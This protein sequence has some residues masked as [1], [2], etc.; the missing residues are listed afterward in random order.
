M[1]KTSQIQRLYRQR[2]SDQ[3]RQ[4]K[5]RLWKVLVESFFQKWIAPNDAVLDLGCGFGEFLNHV[6]AGRRIGVD[7][8]PDAPGFLQAGIEFH[9]GPVTD[10]A[11]LPDRSVQVVFTS[12]V[13]EHLASKAEVDRVLAES[14][15]VLAP[16][17]AIIAMGPNLRVLPGKYWD[18]W[19]HVVPITDWS[20]AEALENAGFEIVSRRAR[21][22]PYSTVRSALPAH[23]ALVALYLKMPFVWPIMGGQ[24]L[25]RA[26][27]PI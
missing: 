23:P 3:Q 20:L 24:F 21:F 25:I 6:R 2:F 22:L 15:R 9:H 7:M 19:D 11:F 27:K 26:R 5:A 16:G 14:L 1:D 12:N 10:L 4:A 8:N 17:G 13:L 18:F